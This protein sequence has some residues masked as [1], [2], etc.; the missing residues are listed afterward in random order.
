MTQHHQFREIARHYDDLMHGVPY[1]GWVAYLEDI[2]D[3]LG[4]HPHT[5]L[6][7]ACG[8]GNVSEILAKRGFEVVGVDISAEMI[9]IAQ[10]KKSPVEYHVQDMAELCIGCHSEPPSCHSEHSEESRA[11]PVEARQFD[12]AVSFFDS[13]NYVT[14]PDHLRRGI[15]R[16]GEHVVPGGLFIFDINTIYALSHHFFDQANLGGEYYPKYIWSSEYDHS[17]RICRVDMLFKVMEDGEEREFKEI[18]YQRGHSIEE[19]TQ[20]LNEGGFDVVDIFHAYK[21][22]RPTRRSDRVFFV[23]RKRA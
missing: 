13:L 21:F 1:R 15:K 19:L 9:E 20:W 2:L 14:D 6:D 23:A 22:R 17:T 3:R 4:Y 7:V 18:H 12:L 8:T 5:I 16:I 10:S 11:E